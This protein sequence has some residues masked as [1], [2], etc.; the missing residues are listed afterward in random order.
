MLEWCGKRSCSG[1]SRPGSKVSV[2]RRKNQAPNLNLKAAPGDPL[3]L[4]TLDLLSLLQSGQDFYNI[5]LLWSLVTCGPFEFSE[6]P[7]AGRQSHRTCFSLDLIQRS[8]VILW[9]I[10]KHKPS[11]LV[12]LTVK[13]LWIWRIQ[14]RV[15]QDLYIH[16]I[17]C[18]RLVK[19]SCIS[20]LRCSVLFK[21][22]KET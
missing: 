7:L 11:H 21:W 17:W 9:D 6:N 22:I 2:K 18:G 12:L 3:P 10:S 13:G 8:P 16:G 20:F 1:H 14:W 4:G 19:M 5:S 15:S